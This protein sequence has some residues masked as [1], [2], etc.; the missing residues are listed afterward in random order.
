MP[1]ATPPRRV[2]AKEALKILEDAYSYY[3]P[4]HAPTPD[5]AEPAEYFEYFTTT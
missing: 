1:L 3:S 2:S 4:G 5:R